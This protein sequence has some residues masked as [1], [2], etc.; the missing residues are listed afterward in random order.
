MNETALK[1]PDKL[2]RVPNDS[3]GQIKIADIGIDQMGSA[4]GGKKIS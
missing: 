2:K 4:D 3:G 1:T